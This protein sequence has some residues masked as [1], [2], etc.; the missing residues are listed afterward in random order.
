MKNENMLKKSV[1]SMVKLKEN[2]G[3]ELIPP[4]LK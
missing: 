4:G 3:I 1:W 2:L